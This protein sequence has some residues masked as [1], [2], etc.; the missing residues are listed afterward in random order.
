MRQSGRL[1]VVSPSVF[2]DQYVVHVLRSSRRKQTSIWLTLPCGRAQ[3]ERRKRLSAIQRVLKETLI[4]K[5]W[6]SGRDLKYLEAE[7]AEHNERA[8]SARIE[9]ILTFLFPP[10]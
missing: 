1:A 6:K 7:G 8:W 3:W 9:Q 10:K 2:A 5:G 4:K